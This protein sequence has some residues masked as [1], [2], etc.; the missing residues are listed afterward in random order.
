MDVQPPASL[1]S[2]VGNPAEEEYEEEMCPPSAGGARA[3]H[4]ALG[5]LVL[6]RF[7]FQCATHVRE[8]I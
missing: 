7:V 2:P 6:G 4:A 3:G 1:E 5:V 8:K